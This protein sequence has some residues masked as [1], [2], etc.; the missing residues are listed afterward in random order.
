M[1]NQKIR[2]LTLKEVLQYRREKRA[3]DG[4]EMTIPFYGRENV[5]AEGSF[6]MV[7]HKIPYRFSLNKLTAYFSAGVSCLLEIYLYVDDDNTTTI[8][9][10]NPLAVYSPSPFLTGDNRIMEADINGKEFEENK[11][12]KIV[13]I[14]KGIYPYSINAKVSITIYPNL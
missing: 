6:I 2:P 9:G 1:I 7:S 14:N 11:Y 8:K 12:I 10:Y 5:P 3:W 13:G 4:Y